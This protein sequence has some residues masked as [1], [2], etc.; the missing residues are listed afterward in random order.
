G[1]RE[2]YDN[3]AP[4][5]ERIAA[6]TDDGPCVTYIG[7]DGAGHYVKMVH[8][9]I[10]YGDMQLIAEAYDLLKRLGG[11][12]NAELADVFDEWN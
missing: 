4:A 6:Q 2:G 12:S 7:P 9:G 5:L 10:E 8:N 1:P 3:L 11:L